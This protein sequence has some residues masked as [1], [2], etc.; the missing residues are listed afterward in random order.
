MDK[1][2]LDHV[3]EHARA[4]LIAMN[5]DKPGLATNHRDQILRELQAGRYVKDI[6]K[7]LGVNHSAIS[8]A[9]AKDKDY[10]INR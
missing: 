1:D 3:P 4:G 9:L 8:H 10:A 6:A 7:D 2:T 5:Q